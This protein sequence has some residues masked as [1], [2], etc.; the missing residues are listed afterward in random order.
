[1]KLVRF[2]IDKNTPPTASDRDPGVRW[3][4]LDGERYR[5]L[6]GDPLGQ[7]VT[8]ERLFEPDEVRLLPCC[9]PSKIVCIGRNYLEHAKELNNPVPSEPLIFLKP[10]S[11]LI[12]SGDEILYP[13]ESQRVDFEGELGIVIGHRCSQVGPEGAL[14][15]AFGYTCV[16]DVTA[17]DLQKK[18]VQ[19]TRGKG[20]DTFCAVGPCL[21]PKAELDAAQLSVRTW[22]DAEL[23][24]DGNT[25]DLIFPLGVIISFVSQVMTLEPGDLIATGTPAGVG[26]MLPGSTVTVEVEGIGSLRNTVRKR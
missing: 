6:T 17:R 16:N 1:M 18:D 11:A 24:Q 9:T 12:G 5:Q 3:G 22:L 25:R 15:Y 23:K 14:A 10:P 8:S 26:P 19:F 21:V 20:F 7:F 2:S 4:V 13:P